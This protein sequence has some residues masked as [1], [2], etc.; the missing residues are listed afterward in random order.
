MDVEALRYVLTLAEELHF[1]RSA[2][3]HYISEAQFGRRVRRV[4]AELGMRIFD[5]TSR[6]VSVTAEGRVALA[7]A[8]QLLAD[9]DELQG[10]RANTAQPGVLRIGV[11][12][13]GVGD[14]W[15]RLRTLW[16]ATCPEVELVH[17]P[18][19]L[20]DQ[21][22]A[23]LRRVVDV[24]LVHYLGEVDGLDLQFVM[25]TPRVAVVP[26]DS[27]WAGA[28]R[29]D[30]GE[31]DAHRWLRLVGGD[32]RFADWVGQQSQGSGRATVTTIDTVTTAVATTGLIG[33]HGAA[34]AQFY[35]HPDVRFVPLEGAPVATA[36]AT[37]RDDDRPMVRAFRAA[38][39]KVADLPVSL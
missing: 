15:E 31:V 20:A 2:R 33:F 19:T 36:V 30:A 22:T 14:R 6:R 7:R 39:Q 35:A 32:D 12:G 4:E 5:R 3:R 26:V 10:L 17:R 16:R 9:L 34:A 8:Q 29:I 37:R 11:L 27:P 18:L 25:Q 28:E 24:A 23:V 38:A 21:Y 13:F 1:G